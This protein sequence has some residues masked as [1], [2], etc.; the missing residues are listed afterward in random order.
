M[1]RRFLYSL[2]LLAAGAAAGQ[3]YPIRPVPFTEVKLTDRFWALRI[4]INHDVTIPIAINHC[5]RTGRIDNFF[6]AGRKIPGPFRTTYPFDD[7]DIYKIIEGAS[8]SL[9]TFPDPALEAR[10]DTLIEIIGI[11]QEPDGYLYTSRTIDPE[12]P[13][14]WAGSKRWEKDP[15]GSHEL[16]NAGHLYEAAAAHFQ[17][18]GKRSLL[19]IALKNADL[20]V[21][22]FGPGKLAYFPGHQVIEMGLVKLYRVT[23]KREYLDLAKYFLDIRKGGEEYS[24]SHIPVTEQTKAVGHAVRATYLYSGMADVAALIGVPAYVNALNAIWKDLLDSKVYIT[25]GIG[26]AAGIEGFSAAYELSNLS[27]YNETC[28]SIGLVFWCHRMF[29]LTG[30]V[31]YMDVLER[32]LYNGLLSGVSLEGDRFFYPNP[33]ESRGNHERSEWFGCACCP[34]NVC[35]VIPSV[36]GY[37]FAV[38]GKRLIVNLFM[39]GT[40]SV[41]M[42]GKAVELKVQTEY[43]WK[44]DVDI[45]LYPEERG[46]F[47]LAVRIPGWARNEAIPGGLYQFQDHCDSAWTVELNGKPAEQDFENGYTVLKRKWEKG[48]RVTLRLPMPV[49]RVNAD[50]RIE[51]DQGRVSLQRGPLVYCVEWPDMPGV[52]VRHI[53]L[54]SVASLSASVRDGML[55]GIVAIDGQA[56]SLTRLD[57]GSIKEREVPFT[58]IPYFAWANRGPGD[59]QVWIAQSPE[60]LLLPVKTIA[61]SS[62]IS[63]SHSTRELMAVN[64]QEEPSN[65]NDRNVMVYD[66][67]PLK[68]TLQ[69]VRYDFEKPETVSRVRV[70]WFDDGPRGGCRVPESWALHYLDSAGAWKPVTA[71][72]PYSV[73][74]DRFNVLDFRPVRTQALKMEVR[75]SETHSGG[76]LEWAVE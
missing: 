20:V 25:G 6:A 34:G 60:A 14:K 42:D 55:G 46:A 30:D 23:N 67:W 29:L 66:W 1:L 16:Y 68:D 12:H 65:S 9:Q 39:D 54:E 32:V 50:T 71:A 19:N 73:D 74:K 24:Q 36:P 18:T 58:A 4:R 69:W 5:Y 57:D 33:L 47:E 59:M 62:R 37:A 17:A 26:A 31:Q 38:T 13:H 75:L 72:S 64:D 27:A 44:G 53:V 63:G 48:D 45:V 8:F 11:A 15:N 61:S 51:A 22:D 56:K 70:Y 28:A 3:D 76:I 40:T 21:K 10:I 35:R 49:R 7:S 2:M 43:P 52:Q 41:E